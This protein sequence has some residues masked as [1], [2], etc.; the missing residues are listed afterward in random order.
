MLGYEIRCEAI[1]VSTD[2]H[3]VLA[4]PSSNREKST[5]WGQGHQNRKEC[6]EGP[7]TQY[8]QLRSQ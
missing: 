6:V 3:F 4:R 1:K 7:F 8:T 5:Q 2:T